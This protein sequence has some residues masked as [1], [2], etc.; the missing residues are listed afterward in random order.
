MLTPSFLS[1]SF[2]SS[3]GLSVNDL[4]AREMFG[5]ISEAYA[6]LKEM[7]TKNDPDKEKLLV[8]LVK[9]R[10]IA[11]LRVLFPNK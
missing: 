4:Q 7:V 11:A 8:H 5:T 9:E 6:G 2:R 1:I 3:A 10:L